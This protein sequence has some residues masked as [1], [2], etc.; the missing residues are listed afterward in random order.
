MRSSVRR[1]TGGSVAV[2][3]IDLDQFKQINDLYGHAAGDAVLI[4]VTRRMT[5]ALRSDD[6]LARLSGDEFVL[7]CEDLPQ[8][9]DAQLDH[10]LDVVT[11]RL[12]DALTEPVQIPGGSVTAAA[13]IGIAVS[14]ADSAADDL[15]GDADAAMYR[16]KQHRRTGEAYAIDLTSAH[17]STRQLERDICRA[18]KRGELR[19]H[20]QPI[21]TVAEGRAPS[22][23]AV[24][25]L[26]RWEHPVHGLMLAAEFIE[27]A[28]RTGAI[29]PIG[30][31]VIDQ[32]CADMSRWKDRLSMLAPGTVYINVGP[33]QLND[34][35]LGRRLAATMTR[36]TLQ[37]PQIGL[38][39]IEAS[40]VDPHLISRLQNFHF[41]GHPLAV[42]D[43][44]TG[45]S[46]LSRLVEF[47]ADIA[48]IDKSFVAGIA[49]DTR[50][51]ALIDAVIV[52]AR[53][54]GL[55]IIGEGVETAVQAQLLADAGCHLQQGFHHG[56]AV[57]AEQLTERLTRA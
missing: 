25:A 46:S 54:L 38:E 23:A 35:S 19:V 13:S 22:V 51:R 20:Y 5:A 28:E 45:Y 40:F 7:V 47:P 34:Q 2:F 55:S 43:F 41:Q 6:T 48:K 33:R 52:I 29:V 30:H 39:V 31:W 9:T 53:H 49:N 37:P 18:L 14:S 57:S 1:V 50:R 26:L 15:L 4:E 44:G 27:L 56:S 32:V 16:N 42:D 8:R 21:M 36:F 11:R 10:Q 17:R 24:E 12:Q 3:F